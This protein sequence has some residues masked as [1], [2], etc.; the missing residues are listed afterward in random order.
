MASAHLWD[1][2]T[3]QLQMAHLDA[4]VCYSDAGVCYIFG[5]PEEN[6]ETDLKINMLMHLVKS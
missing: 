5:G 2:E 6:K 1:L 3:L 4:G